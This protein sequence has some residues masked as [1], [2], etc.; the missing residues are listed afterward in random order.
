MFGGGGG[1]LSNLGCRDT[2]F[3]II[4]LLNLLW[5]PVINAVEFHCPEI[6]LICYVVHKIS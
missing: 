1:V 2:F 3:K 6:F 5:G 4:A